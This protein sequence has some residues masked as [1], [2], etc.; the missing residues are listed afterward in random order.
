MD[1]ILE[2]LLRNNLVEKTDNNSKVDNEKRL[3]LNPVLCQFISQNI[4]DESLADF[5]NAI[6]KYY[7]K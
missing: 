4:A 7:N 2:V 5:M 3:E 1:M 6:I